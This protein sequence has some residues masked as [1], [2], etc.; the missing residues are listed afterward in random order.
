M[1]YRLLASGFLLI[2]LATPPA[3]D[4]GWLFHRCR[5]LPPCAVA[6]PQPAPEDAI[7]QVLNDQ[8]AAW[9]KGDLDGFMK[10]YWNSPDLTFF[11]GNNKTQGWQA[12]L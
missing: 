11:S 6:M 3:T 12:T 9:N 7:K 1:R 4:A 5:P 10:G 8:V 2:T